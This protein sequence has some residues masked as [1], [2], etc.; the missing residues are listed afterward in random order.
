M[1]SDFWWGTIYE[2]VQFSNAVT[3]LSG[4]FQGIVLEISCQPTLLS[5]LRQT[6]PNERVFSIMS[7]KSKSPV[8]SVIETVSI[9][10]HQG[11]D[12]NWP[13]I[14][15][16]DAKFKVFSDVRHWNHNQIKPKQTQTQ[17][18]HAL[19]LKE[20]KEDILFLKDHMVDSNIVFPGMGYC[21]L[22]IDQKKNS[23]NRLFVCIH[24]KIL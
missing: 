13:N 7:P 3:S 18:L 4:E 22:A 21:L 9:C 20:A 12:I 24:F 10:W 5:Y 15:S 1:N 19:P 2:K 23:N 14:L 8:S 17:K 6:V 11:M 16:E